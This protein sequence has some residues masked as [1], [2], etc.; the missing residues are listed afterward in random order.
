MAYR[1]VGED[2]N[3]REAL[4]GQ[5]GPEGTAVGKGRRLKGGR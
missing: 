1:E 3:T 4:P 5:V 2:N